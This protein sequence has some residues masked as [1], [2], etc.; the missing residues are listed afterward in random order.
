[1]TIRETA[2]ALLA[3]TALLQALRP[4]D[5]AI[6]GSYAMDL[7]SWNDLDIYVDIGEM[8]VE[9]WNAL[10]AR[11]IMA[12][13]PVRIDGFCDAEKGSWFFGTELIF[14]GE[15]WNIDIWGK[16]AQQIE[17]ALAQNRQLRARFD[18]DAAARDAM[19]QI[20]RGLIERK[21]YGFDKGR[22]HFHSPEI[23]AAV[24]E[25]GVRSLEEFL[26]E[27]TEKRL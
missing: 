18:A 10:A 17:A 20:K 9:K 5:A 4:H 25:K 21:M 24:L 1:M 11:V 6:V 23:Y 12:L 22:V 16:T 26:G 14:G 13:Q 8:S 15:R 2:D 27:E 19:L 7:M 3:H